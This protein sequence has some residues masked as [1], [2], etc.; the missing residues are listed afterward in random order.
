MSMTVLIRGHRSS[1]PVLA[2]ACF[3]KANYNTPASHP[4][5]TLGVNTPRGVLGGSV[6]GVSSAAGDYTAVV[7]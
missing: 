4:N 7:P 5:T 2:D 6:A 3:T 1:L